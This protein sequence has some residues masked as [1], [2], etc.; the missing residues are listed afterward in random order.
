MLLLIWWSLL[1]MFLEDFGD[2]FGDED[3]AMQKNGGW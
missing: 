2:P 3:D 1:M